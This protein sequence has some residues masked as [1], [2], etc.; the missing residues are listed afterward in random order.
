MTLTGQLNIVVTIASTATEKCNSLQKYS[1]HPT[2]RLHHRRESGR[3]MPLLEGVVDTRSV[4]KGSDGDILHLVGIFPFSLSLAETISTS[5]SGARS[6]GVRVIV[7][8]WQ[9]ASDIA[10]ALT[11]FG[12]LAVTRK[13]ISA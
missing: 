1:I 12:Q 10:I 8:S 7:V 2:E 13:P 3:P 4:L 6:L 5:Q 11:S 9:L